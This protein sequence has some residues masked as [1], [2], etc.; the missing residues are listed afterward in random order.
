MKYNDIQFALYRKPQI[1]DPIESVQF[2]D[3]WVF[4]GFF[5]QNFA[6][7]NNNSSLFWFAIGEASY[8]KLSLTL[9]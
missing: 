3:Q 1:W 6:G 8:V 5:D 4:A 2:G 9:G 7:N